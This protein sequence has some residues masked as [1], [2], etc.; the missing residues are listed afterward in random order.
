M[1]VLTRNL[2]SSCGLLS[3]LNL[4]LPQNCEYLLLRQAIK[5]T[6]FSI[7]LYICRRIVPTNLAYCDDFAMNRSKKDSK[8]HIERSTCSKKQNNRSTD[9]KKH[10]VHS[11]D[12]ERHKMKSKKLNS[13]DLKWTC[14][15]HIVD[16][17]TSNYLFGIFGRFLHSQ[18]FLSR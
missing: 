7:A 9:T 17:L 3:R 15:Q 6:Q 18:I 16:L 8:R 10:S 11:T 13:R 5:M 4:S 12:S 14:K 2:H 1:T